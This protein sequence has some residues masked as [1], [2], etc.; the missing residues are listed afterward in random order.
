MSKQTA[1]EWLDNELYNL[2]LKLRGFEISFDLYFEQ[3]VKL[4]EQAKAMEKEQILFAYN[5]GAMGAFEKTYKG[6]HEY[7]NENYGGNK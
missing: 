4:I 3:E 1:V 2:R 6:M 5:D 7:Y